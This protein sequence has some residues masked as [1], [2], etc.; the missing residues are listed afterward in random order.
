MTARLHATLYRRTL[1]AAAV[2]L[3]ALVGPSAIDGSTDL[4]RLALVKQWTAEVVVTSD[5]DRVAFDGSRTAIHNRIVTTYQFTQRLPDTPTLTWRGRAT[6]KYKWSVLTGGRDNRE[7]EESESSF[8]IDSELR[9]GDSLT[10]AA[11]GRPPARPFT[12]SRYAG[13][14]VVETST[15]NDWPPS[16]ELFDA[17][18]PSDSGTLSGRRTESA[19]SLFGGAVI[20]CP[21]QRQWVVRP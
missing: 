21:A 12:R 9:L 6:T 15:M 7:I 11:I 5:C 17:P 19:Y 16:A 20:N 1:G 10:I 4:A 3:A 8:D 14:A 2:V 18:L 13:D